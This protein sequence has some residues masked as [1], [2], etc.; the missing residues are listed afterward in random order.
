MFNDHT[1][2]W[3]TRWSC[4][5]FARAFASLAQELW[6]Q[7][8]DQNPDDILLIGEIWFVPD[9]SRYGPFPNY[10][11]P[12]APTPLGG[13]AICPCLTEQGHAFCDPQTA[14]TTGGIND[15]SVWHL[16]P[17]ELQSTYRL[18]V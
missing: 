6:S 17:T 7:S 12:P 10:F 1:Q 16:L 4:R 15:R 14:P 3:K 9:A 18:R 11:A 2:T 5:E 8:P 13:H